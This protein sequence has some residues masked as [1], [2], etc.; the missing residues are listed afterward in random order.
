MRSNLSQE[1]F[2]EWHTHVRQE[3][4]PYGEYLWVRERRS[5]RFVERYRVVAL[6]EDPDALPDRGELDDVVPIEDAERFFDALRERFA[7]EDYECGSTN[8]TNWS[9][10]EKHALAL[11]DYEY[12]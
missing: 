3:L 12:D 11:R 8:S 5:G 6:G 1:R 2:F 7:K 9:G 10:V 4:A